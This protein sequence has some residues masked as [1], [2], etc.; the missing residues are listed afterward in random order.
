MRNNIEKYNLINNCCG[1]SACANICPRNAITMERN[2]NGFY[3]PKVDQIKCNECG[4]CLKTC[5]IENTVERNGIIRPVACVNSNE[6]ERMSSSSGGIVPLLYKFFL[7]ID[8][9]TKCF[10]VRWNSEMNAVFDSAENEN[11]LLMFRGSKYVQSYIGE[12]YKEIGILL[13]KG[14]NVLFIG[15]GCQCAGLKLYLKNKKI[16]E[17]KLFLVDIVC[18]G[19]PS[20]K[21]WQDYLR[22]LEEK[23]KVV[24]TDYAFRN[25]KISWHGIHPVII[26]ENN[27][28]VEDDELCSSYGRLFGSLSLN[29]QCHLCKYANTNRCTDLTVGDYWGIENSS[30]SLDSNKGVSLC[31]INSSKGEQLFSLIEESLEFEIIND[32]SYLQPQ[33]LNPTHINPRNRAFWKEYRKK[34]FLY[35][36]HKYTKES[37]LKN[38]LAPIYLRMKGRKKKLNISE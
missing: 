6:D 15:S 32:N 34:G 16:S 27:R 23:N 31:L 26:T 1:C 36:A 29:M 18:H 21:M 19:M 30:C 7:K 4:L 8:D 28:S 25:K 12:A 14:V 33:L 38:I 3:N 22:T 2:I 9:K 20:P 10:G 37:L 13:K 17:E 11:Q 5:Q 35:V 24:I